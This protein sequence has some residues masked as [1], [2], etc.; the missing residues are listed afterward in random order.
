MAA[1]LALRL[2]WR[3]LGR[4]TLETTRAAPLQ[5]AESGDAR[6]SSPMKFNFTTRPYNLTSYEDEAEKH[7]H[8]LAPDSEDDHAPGDIQP[9]SVE[10]RWRGKGCDKLFS[11]CL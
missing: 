1:G 10:S 3:R 6:K 5:Y 4:S 8:V 7:E 2:P 11:P 9:A